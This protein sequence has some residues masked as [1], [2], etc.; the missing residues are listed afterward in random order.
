M[1]ES[2]GKGNL[3]NKRDEVSKDKWKDR[4]IDPPRSW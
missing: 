3:D 1:N 2:G 4:G